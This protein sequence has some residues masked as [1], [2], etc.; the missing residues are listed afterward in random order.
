[1]LAALQG[2]CTAP[3][4]AHAALIEGPSGAP[5]LELLGMLADP[6][7]TQLLRASH[8]ASADEPELLGRTLAAT[9]LSSGGDEVLD[10]IRSEAS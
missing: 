3:I 1:M 9:L 10:R 8:E 7:G 4:G 2:G 5:R 6:N